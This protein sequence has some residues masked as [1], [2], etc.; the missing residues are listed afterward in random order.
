MD[1][2]SDWRS[3]FPLHSAAEASDALLQ[4][5][6]DLAA[7]PRPGFNRRTREPA[8]TKRLKIHVEN[9]IAYERGLLGMWAVENTIGDIDPS[10][11]ELLEER[12]TDI[13]YGWNDASNRFELVFEFKRVRKGK[14]DRDKYLGEEGLA[15]F[16]T[17]LYSRNQ[18]IAAMVG[19]LLAPKAAIVPPIR[20]A[21][22]NPAVA[23]RL[24]LRA[25]PSGAPYT[26]PSDLFPEEAD[27]DTE[28]HRDPRLAPPHGYISVAH[29]FVTFPH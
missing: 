28:H 25:H 21:L 27:F 17:G 16:V 24:R 10:T 29:F 26:D 20:N 18:P 14:H 11:G 19:I 13:V 12:R 22:S 6:R 4:G 8:L 7:V 23:A 15:R 2:V 5:W 1:A 3:A 9:H